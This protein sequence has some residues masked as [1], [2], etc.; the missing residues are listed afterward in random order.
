[1]SHRGPSAFIVAA[2]DEAAAL[3]AADRLCRAGYPATMRAYRIAEDLRHD[4]NVAG[5]ATAEEASRLESALRAAGHMT[6]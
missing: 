2:V 3:T 6:R 1:M 4:V 5:L